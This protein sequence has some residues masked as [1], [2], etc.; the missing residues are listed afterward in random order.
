LWA[1][2]HVMLGAGHTVVRPVTSAAPW[3]TGMP[4]ETKQLKW[5]RSVALDVLEPGAADA[6]VW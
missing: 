2:I 5:P 1:N 6:R 3:L 4:G